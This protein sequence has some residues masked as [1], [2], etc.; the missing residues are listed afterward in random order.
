MI[1]ILLGPPGVGKGTQAKLLANRFHIPHV[2]TGDILRAAVASKSPL[3][4]KADG[5]LRKGEFVPDE[6]MVDVVAEELK[7]PK[8]KR[9]FILD[10]F[11]RTIAQAE[12]LEALFERLHAS[13]DAVLSFEATEEELIRRLSRR[14]MCRSCHSIFNLDLDA[15]ADPA[16][17]PRCGGELY[18]RDDDKEETIKNRF[19]VHEQLTAPLKEFYAKKKALV[20]VNGVGQIQNIYKNILAI[21]EKCRDKG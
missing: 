18:Q 20:P 9:G 21:L 11:P 2:S 19:R 15:I 16:V 6:T 17:C 4:E 7:Q 3:G 1:L 12:A 10:G 13:L 5:Y 8:Y 14:R